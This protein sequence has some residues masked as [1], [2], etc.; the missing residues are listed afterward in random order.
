MY[1]ISDTEVPLLHAVTCQTPS[2][3][4]RC[5]S[6]MGYLEPRPSNRPLPSGDKEL[7][8]PKDIQRKLMEK[9]T[10]LQPDD[11]TEG[12]GVVTEAEPEATPTST[13]SSSHSSHSLN[14]SGSVSSKGISFGSI[15]KR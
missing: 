10:H 5:S 3:D 6:S 15:F 12:E 14:S 8:S 11:D 7:P 1:I 13:I 2:E 4:S 9:V